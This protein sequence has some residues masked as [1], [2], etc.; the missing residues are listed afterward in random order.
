MRWCGTVVVLLILAAAAHAQVPVPVGPP[1]PASAEPPYDPA[2]DGQDDAIIQEMLYGTFSAE[3][4]YSSPSLQ[5]RIQDQAGE[6]IAAAH[7]RGSRQGQRIKKTK[8]AIDGGYDTADSLK[9]MIAELQKRIQIAEY[10]V[11]RASV[12]KDIVEMARAER[13]R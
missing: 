11:D 7:R 5:R 4:I 3:E 8:E 6:M 12:L 1:I 10:A 9:P 2:A 13:F